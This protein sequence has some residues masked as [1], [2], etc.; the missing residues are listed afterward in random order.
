MHRILRTIWE[1]ISCLNTLSWIAQLIA[2]GLGAS[3]LSLWAWYLGLS[4]TVIAAIAVCVFA[5][6]VWLGRALNHLIRTARREIKPDEVALAEWLSG[7]ENE[8]LLPIAAHLMVEEEPFSEWSNASYSMYRRFKQE[9]D[10][11]RLHAIQLN[12][13]RANVRTIVSRNDLT[14]LARRIGLRSRF[15]GTE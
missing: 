4:G 14:E 8:Y 2:G 9:I 11:G 15:L 13:E 10:N 3:V 12:G 6:I 7:K 5:A 1:W